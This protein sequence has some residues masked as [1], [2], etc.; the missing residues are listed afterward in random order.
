M[1][2]LNTR[3]IAIAAAILLATA[4]SGTV[5][6]GP[7]NTAVTPTDRAASTV[8]APPSADQPAVATAAAVPQP[9]ARKP[10]LGTP[11]PSTAVAATATPHVF[12][13]VMENESLE[14][15]LQQPYVA[16]L[17][18]TYAVATNYHAVGS[19]SLPNYLALTSG[20]TW[21]IQDDGYRAL[22]AGGIGQQ[23]DAA[24]IAWR[25]YMEGL[26]ARGCVGSPDPY[27]VK[28]N[29]FAYYG[30][31]CPKNVVPFGRSRISGFGPMR[32]QSSSASILRSV[33]VGLRR[34]SAWK[35]TSA[36][37]AK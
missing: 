1:V 34:S 22:P 37:A 26:T 20:S 13:I 8:T 4:C 24:G 19:P 32:S 7:A 33:D 9:L 16:R 17:A 23:L 5:A 15:V 21:G 29:P 25:A 36:R 11:A 12:V 14:P 18:A 10:G 31:A 6:A 28:H 35:C 2:G 30:G 3:C 27:A